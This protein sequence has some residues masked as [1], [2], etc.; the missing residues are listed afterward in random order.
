M[1]RN[2]RFLKNGQDLR[3]APFFALAALMPLLNLVGVGN[4]I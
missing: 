1:G 2:Q 3:Q 4:A